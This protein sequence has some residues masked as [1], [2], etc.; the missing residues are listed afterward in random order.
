MNWLALRMRV[1]PTAPLPR[2][3]CGRSDG[4]GG[5]LPH[6]LRAASSRLWLHRPVHI[7]AEAAGLCRLP[8]KTWSCD[9]VS[10]NCRCSAVL[11]RKDIVPVY[12]KRVVGPTMAAAIRIGD[13]AV[14]ND[15]DGGGRCCS[16]RKR[17]EQ[18]NNSLICP[19]RSLSSCE[20]KAAFLYSDAAAQAAPSGAAAQTASQPF[21]AHGLCPSVR[22]RL[23]L[24]ADVT[25]LMPFPKG[26]MAV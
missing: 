19:A 7:T 8:P 6:R 15:S 11:F 26:E 25:R 3:C 10:L 5:G 18:C 13:E 9:G 4:I 12:A 14:V 22:K 1:T 23:S 24:L 16:T 2:L 17:T 20:E 21:L